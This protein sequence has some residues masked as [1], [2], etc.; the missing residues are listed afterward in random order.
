MNHP[1]YEGFQTYYGDL[2][3][4]CDIGY[5]HGTIEDAYR[6]AR[7]QLD[8]ASV[9]AHA[10]WPDLP[11][12]DPRLQSV[13]DYHR[14]GFARAA[15]NWSQ[16]VAVTEAANAP[17]QFVSLPSVE[18]HSLRYGDHNIYFKNGSP[19]IIPATD[20][21]DLRDRVRQRGDDCFII[22]HHIG[23]R[24]GYRGIAWDD[25]TPDYSP[26]VEI[27]SMHGLSESDD[28]AYPYLHTMGP[29]DERST[30]QYGLAQGHVVGVIGSTDHHGAHPGSYGHGR[31]G[32]WATDLTRES[33]WAAIGQ[34]RTYALTGDNIRLALAL[35]GQPMGSVLSA[36]S[37]RQLTVAVEGSAALDTVELLR[38]NRVIQRHDVTDRPATDVFA[39]PVKVLF[40]V[41]WGDKGVETDWQ[42][43]LDV[44]GGQL[45]QVEPHLRGRDI[46]APQ[47][48]DD[49]AYSFSSWRQAAE[50]VWLETRTWGN[51]TTTTSGTQGLCLTIAGD[52]Q[53][54]LMG[55]INGQPIDTPLGDLVSGSR[56]GYLGGLLTPA[57]CFHRVVPATAYTSSLVVTD[58]VDPGGR[59]RDWYYVR[60]RQKNNQ[61]AWSSPIWV[62]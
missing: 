58:R 52:A 60:V 29:S 47:A 6:N 53:T 36:T 39:Q 10:Y 33:L 14:Q 45:Q 8:F 37:E 2:H 28:A 56:S 48:G 26:I 44:H 22:P 40:E 16:F 55:T 1:G 32:V 24:A 4:H 5:G 15:A 35:N 12:D 62:G 57:W 50:T 20:L 49:S 46:L 51:P 11:D 34:R 38:N 21:P 54:R 17:G 9:T 42:I 43:Q 19:A 31:L 7:L 59:G 30:W 23:Y 27:M 61:W 25:F 18:W 13:V 41:G 3:S